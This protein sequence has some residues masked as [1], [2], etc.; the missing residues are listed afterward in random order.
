[1]NTLRGHMQWEELDLFRR[2]DEM[3]RLGHDMFDTANFSHAA[4]PVFGAEAEEDFGRLV[5][6]IRDEATAP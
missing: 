3:I 6:C 1:M 2:V 5:D 4:D